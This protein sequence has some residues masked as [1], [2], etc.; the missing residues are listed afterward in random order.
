MKE[1]IFASY[2]NR[3]YKVS[4]ISVG[5]IRLVSDDKEDIQFGFEKKVYP[6]NYSNPGSLPKVYVKEVE[7]IHITCIYKIQY[8]ARYKHSIVNVHEQKADRVLLGTNNSSLAK[9]L[10]FDRTD[11]YYYEKWVSLDE[12]EMIE[13]RKEM[14]LK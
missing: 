10:N 8:R 1:G 5:K 12:V 11:K 4:E 2:K 3:T 7:Q 9:K 13:E 14:E 6:E